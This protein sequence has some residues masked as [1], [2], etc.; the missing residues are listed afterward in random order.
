MTVISLEERL[1]K[2]LAGRLLGCTDDIAGEDEGD[3]ETLAELGHM[4]GVADMAYV[5]L[6]DLALHC[7]GR[8]EDVAWGIASGAAEDAHALAA[9]V[10][11]WIED[12]EDED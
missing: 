12:M 5:A 2:E 11:D 1:A 3:D 6:S 9:I 4:R 10:G 8:R 7:H